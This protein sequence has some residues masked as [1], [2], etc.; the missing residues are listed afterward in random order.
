ME[1]EIAAMA[2]IFGGHSWEVLKAFLHLW[3]GSAL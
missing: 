3:A 1:D 2:S